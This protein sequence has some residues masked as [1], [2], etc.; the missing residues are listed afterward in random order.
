M[1][2]YA[3]IH[4]VISFDFP[5]DKSF[6]ELVDILKKHYNSESIAATKHFHFFNAIRVPESQLAT[7]CSTK[8][9]RWLAFNYKFSNFIYEALGVCGM[10][11]E[12]AQKVLLKKAN[13]TLKQAM[14]ISQ[15]MEEAPLQSK[16]LKGS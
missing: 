7:V 2:H 15:G 16:N 12:H 8:N 5:K 6:I 9:L 3:L 1:A 4:I 10:Q 13:L 11:S 14:E